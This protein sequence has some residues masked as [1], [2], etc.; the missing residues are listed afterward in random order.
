MLSLI[1]Q[2]R[3]QQPNLSISLER[4]TCEHYAKDWTAG[5]S[6]CAGAVLFPHDT[7][8]VQ[9]I[10]QFANTHQIKLVPSGG[11]TG[12]SAGAVARQQEWVVSL[13]KMQRIFSF[14][15]IDR[16][17]H[18]QAGV[19]TQ[20]LQTLALEKGC[21]FPVDFASRGSSQIGGNVA[22]NA[23]G[24]KVLRYGLL[25]DW[26]A[27]LTV[28][29]G[30]GD[31]L[32]LNQGLVKNATGYDLRHLMI[33]SEGTLGVITEVQL[34]LTSPPVNQDVILL[35]V[36]ELSVMNQLLRLFRQHVSLSAFEFLSQRALEVVLTRKQVAHPL[37]TKA[38]FYVL[39]EFDN[40]YQ[41]QTDQALVAFEQALT[42]AW[43]TDGV[44]SKSEE[45]AQQLWAFRE[46]IS[47][48]LAKSEPYKNDIAVKPS[49]VPAFLKRLEEIMQEHY[50]D[51][52]V[53]WFG[54]IGDGNLH[55]NVLKPEHLTFAR[56]KEHCQH[57][58]RL[59][60]EE[61]RRFGGTI[62]AEHGVGLLKQP[63]LSYVRS[64]AEVQY[65][66]AIK[67]AFDPKGI[68]NPGKLLAQDSHDR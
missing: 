43:A 6:G 31:V 3:E 8:A 41:T 51:Y 25:R 34:R 27:G 53:V 66:G 56:F 7:Q 18:C 58:N 13:D 57:V 49:C 55:L 14:D 23:G 20:T 29:T 44:M 61:V 68:L 50:P 28:V 33:G 16:L 9:A 17:V 24:I 19:I 11:R 60:F 1:E 4:S 46:E 21:Y 59:V 38:P 67:Q 15:P 10:V 47:E 48:T 5:Y 36:P 22:T 12:L 35:A 64:E 30:R 62:S 40:A 63:Y 45:Q 2:L 52:E 42:S 37:Q 26:I 65:L 54:H 32:N 39:I